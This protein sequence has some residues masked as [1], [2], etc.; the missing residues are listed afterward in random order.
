MIA[1]GALSLAAIAVAGCFSDRGLAIEVDVDK[2]GA[3][4]VEL[5]IGQTECD[6]DHSAKISCE[7]IGPKY[8]GTAP[9][10]AQRLDGRIWFRDAEAR[11][12]A[13]VKDGVATFQLQA[14]A[15]TT[16]P[17][18]IAVG[19]T[20]PAGVNAVGT[21]TLLDLTPPTTTARVVTT[22]LISAT[23]TLD[24]MG[25]APSDGD[26]VQVW[27]K[28]TRP[29]SCVMVEHWQGGVLQPP[30]DFV[31]PADD[32]DCDD[33]DPECDAAAWRGTENFGAAEPSVNCFDGGT[34]GDPCRLG[35]KQCSDINPTAQTCGALP[36]TSTI[37]QPIDCVPSLLC[38]STCLPD[39][40]GCLHDRLESGDATL[41]MPRIDCDVP[42][43]SL[44]LGGVGLCAKASSTVSLDGY[45]T[46][47][48]C[49]PVGIST[50]LLAQA[51]LLQQ[52]PFDSSASF[53]GATMTVDDVGKTMGGGKCNLAISSDSGLTDLS[54]QDGNVT[55]AGVIALHNAA[56]LLLLPIILRFQ[57]HADGCFSQLSCTIKGSMSDTMWQCSKGP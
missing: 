23:T 26:R 13:P 34:N 24:D 1:T 32:P 48:S 21:A 39:D 18:V 56:Q 50:L 55:D 10:P 35:T 53:H 19:S 41:D 36:P 29:S 44:P 42:I 9:P 20:D 38:L 2:T 47:D 54:L 15:G 17:I 43:H 28:Q 16:L 8:E 6:A 45:F 57:F 3:T 33:V 46:G 12:T 14:A 49:G 27:T 22:R 4:M 25:P 11:Y 5:F 51:Q 52:Q 7:S 30:R 37:A 31:V 40:S